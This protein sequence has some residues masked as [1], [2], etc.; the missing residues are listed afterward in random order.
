MNLL[1]KTRK[2]NEVLQA[3]DNVQVVDLANVLSAVEGGNV[4]C[5]NAKGMILGYKQLPKC[6]DE[7]RLVSVGD[8]KF[9]PEV[10]TRYLQNVIETKVVEEEKAEGDDGVKSTI[11]VPVY[12]EN[13]RLGSMVVELNRKDVKNDDIILA[14]FAATALG[15]AILREDAAYN[16]Q[17]RNCNIA[18]SN[19]S[20]S[21]KR[22]I[23]S[24]FAEMEGNECYLVASKIA[25]A[26][27]I[28]RSV[29]VNALRK[30]EGAGVIET[31]SLGMKGTYIRIKASMLNEVLEN[32]GF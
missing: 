17:V 19:L 28:T 23:R 24:I 12:T 22:A 25:D 5:A 15:A 30:L 29:I 7:E 9:F 13:R 21:E 14:E 6:I 31:R 10:Y 2:L 27:G 32:A 4:Y 16:E 18:V 20:F 8:D 1:E 26:V 3:Y 11:I